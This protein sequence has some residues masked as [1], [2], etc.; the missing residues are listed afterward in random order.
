MAGI[1]LESKGVRDIRFKFDK[2]NWKVN[3]PEK[4][5]KI[6]RDRDVIEDAGEVAHGEESR[7]SAGDFGSIPVR[8]NAKLRK[9]WRSAL[10]GFERVAVHISSSSRTWRTSI[11][12]ELLMIPALLVPSLWLAILSGQLPAF[13]NRSGK[14]VR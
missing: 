13:R 8:L 10:H 4:L 7:C 12:V 3:V 1:Q 6:A 14:E 11:E 9:E 5:N 2:P